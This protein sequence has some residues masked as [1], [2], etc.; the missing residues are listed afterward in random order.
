MI[1]QVL[2]LKDA[3]RKE[4]N[5][6]I[7]LVNDTRSK[8][9]S[10]EDSIPESLWISQ[11]IVQMIWLKIN[12][13]LMLAEGTIVTTNNSNYRIFDCSSI[14]PIVRSAYEL[15]FVYHNI[16]I[17]AETNIEQE[18]LLNIWKIRG[19]NSRQNMLTLPE[20][21]TTRCESDLQRISDLKA[22]I[23]SLVS[24]LEIS[25]DAKKDIKCIINYKG[26]K[27]KGFKFIKENGKITKIEDIHVNQGVKEM[28]Q[29]KATEALFNWTSM[30][31][32]ASY[33]SLR[34][35]GQS[36]KPDEAYYKQLKSILT[37]AY[38]IITTVLNDFKSQII[39]TE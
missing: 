14:L 39:K 13:I 10:S 37:S 23:L 28:P 26:D 17:T 35:F 31:T 27:I 18:I 25:D 1:Q 33:L 21:Y 32:H 8:W 2:T 9:E 29:F 30:H 4:L 6:T 22:K 16:F 7:D 38:L 20:R 11:C 24:K 5:S 12:T 15:C 19:Y 36:Y 3:L 34:Q